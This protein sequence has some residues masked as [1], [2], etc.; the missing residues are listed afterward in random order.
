MKRYHQGL[1]AIEVVI[2]AAI[3]L[4]GLLALIGAY[5]TYV[6]YAFANQKNVQASYLMEEGL[7]AM[8]FLRDKGWTTY[9]APL[10]SSTDYYMV[11]TGGFWQ[12]TTTPQYVDGEFLRKIII[13][14]VKRDGSDKISDSGTVDTNIKK[15]TVIID[16]FQG[17]ATT[18]KSVSTYITNL[19]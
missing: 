3:I 4:A 9:I 1:G 15:I 5:T 6:Q 7:E 14:E 18:T 19:Y 17:K 16:Y 11:F 10:A 8:T 13:G 12:T 2:G